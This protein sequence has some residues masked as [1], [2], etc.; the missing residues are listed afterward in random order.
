MSTVNPIKR[1]FVISRSDIKLAVSSNEVMF[2]VCQIK[3]KFGIGRSEIKFAV[4]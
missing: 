2:I 1:N 3:I 4:S